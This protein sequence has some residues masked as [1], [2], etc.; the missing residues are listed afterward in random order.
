[1]WLCYCILCFIHSFHFLSP[2]IAMVPNG[3]VKLYQLFF[4]LRSDFACFRPDDCPMCVLCILHVYKVHCT[5][6][7]HS[8]CYLRPIRF[9]YERILR[10]WKQK[11]KI[12]QEKKCRH[13]QQT[14]FVR[15]AHFTRSNL[16]QWASIELHTIYIE[17]DFISFGHY[18]WWLLYF[19]QTFWMSVDAYAH[20]H[21]I[22]MRIR[23][24]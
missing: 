8:Y 7:F 12:Y 16:W 6:S 23:T 17:C 3:T 20:T 21:F 14:L 15:L 4:R 24:I 18:I 2:Q 1:M 5:Q 11:K 19:I 9:E 13:F 10:R 22:M